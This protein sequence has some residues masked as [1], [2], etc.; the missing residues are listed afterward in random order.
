MFQPEHSLK[1]FDSC[2]HFPANL[3]GGSSLALAKF[4]QAHADFRFEQ[5]GLLLDREGNRNRIRCSN[6]NIT[7]RL[8]RLEHSGKAQQGFRS[9]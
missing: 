8:F 7:H 4:W 3:L 9:I 5:L 1:R 6:R 2:R